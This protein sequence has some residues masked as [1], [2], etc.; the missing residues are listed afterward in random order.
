MSSINNFI[1]H[2]EPLIS[3]EYQNAIDLEAKNKSTTYTKIPLY[4]PVAHKIERVN[5]FF[6]KP[7]YKCYE[8]KRVKNYRDFKVKPFSVINFWNE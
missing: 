4:K 5:P 6:K 2:K 8:L 1:Q 3:P 7:T